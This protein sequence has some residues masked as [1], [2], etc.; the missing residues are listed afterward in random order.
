MKLLW[1]CLFTAVV[2]V[3]ALC[4]YVYL[5]YCAAERYIAPVR[6]YL[7]YKGVIWGETSGRFAFDGGKPGMRFI[8]EYEIRDGLSCTYNGLMV[9]VDM[10]LRVQGIDGKYVC[11]NRVVVSE[12]FCSQ[13]LREVETIANERNQK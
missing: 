7:D 5:S 8:H 2:I 6:D 13:I 10:A 1:V 12:A 11:T 4:V 9:A 3:F